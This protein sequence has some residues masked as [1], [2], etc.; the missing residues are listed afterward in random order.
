MTIIF[1]KSFQLLLCE[2]LSIMPIDVIL[3]NKEEPP[4]DKN[5]SVTPQALQK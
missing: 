3:T 2:I 5:G 1:F 4:Y